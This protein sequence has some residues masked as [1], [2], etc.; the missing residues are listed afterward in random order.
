MI[1]LMEC[2]L[3][4]ERG[5]SISRDSAESKGGRENPKSQAPSP[6]EAR[7]PNLYETRATA[8]SVWTLGFLGT[9]SLGFG[10]WDLELGHYSGVPLRP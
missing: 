10:T 8:F 4:G 2:G 9:W 6:K 1:G 5:V 3:G 7:N